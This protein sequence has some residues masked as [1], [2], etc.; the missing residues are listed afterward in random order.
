MW[1][2]WIILSI[3]IIVVGR[4]IAFNH[5][6]NPSS[7]RAEQGRPGDASRCSGLHDK[8]NA[9]P[10][11]LESFVTSNKL[12]GI[13]HRDFIFIVLDSKQKYSFCSRE[14][15]YL[16]FPS[17][18]LYIYPWKDQNKG[19]QCFSKMCRNARLRKLSSK[20]YIISSEFFNKITLASVELISIYIILYS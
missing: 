17:C 5:W 9:K 6:L 16:Y 20:N 3:K 1:D 14:K 7:H 18:S 19:S 10:R 11:E 4:V 2:T 13:C 15:C 12:P 8:R